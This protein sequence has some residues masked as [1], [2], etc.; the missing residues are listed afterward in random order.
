MEEIKNYE[1]IVEQIKK[2]KKLAEEG[3]GG[4]RENAKVL[5]EKLLKKYKITLD[6]LAEEKKT[7]YK[8]KYKTL[9]EKKILIQCI[10]KFAPDVE[11]AKLIF[12]DKGK[13]RIN[14]IGVELT[15]I[16]FL[17]VEAATK[18]YSKLFTKE[19]ELFYMA[20]ISKHDIFRER[21]KNELVEESTL[22]PEEI[23]AIIHMMNGL[24]D[25]FYK[26]NKR[27]EEKTK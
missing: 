10:A 16:Q 7:L 8:F 3:V 1:S 6:E 14:I 15:K 20:F 27:L 19:L 17:D 12:D 24:S 11:N 5:L 2:V 25:N 13:L 22:S 23:E 21:D 26:P 4:E 18:F 9:F